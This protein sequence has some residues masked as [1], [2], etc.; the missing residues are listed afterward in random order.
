MAVP[1]T[2]KATGSWLIQAIIK[3]GADHPEYYQN[4]LAVFMQTFHGNPYCY[5]VKEG[6]TMYGI[7]ETYLEDGNFY[8]W[9]ADINEIA[10]PD[11]IYKGQ[12]IEVP[13]K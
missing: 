12:L 7:A 1:I 13:I 2:D 8:P 9:L 5:R 6:D 11:L 3:K 10:D 4:A